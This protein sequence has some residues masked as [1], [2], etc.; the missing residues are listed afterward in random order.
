MTDSI[1]AAR[2]LLLDTKQTIRNWDGLDASQL[3][4]WLML[5]LHISR[6]FGGA[7]TF[8]QNDYLELAKPCPPEL[9]HIDRVWGIDQRGYV[10]HGAQADEITHYDNL[11]RTGV[12]RWG[13]R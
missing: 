10:L 7:E 13:Y 11:V 2:E 8:E 12:P 6:N 9:Q 3:R 5:C 1:A 4:D